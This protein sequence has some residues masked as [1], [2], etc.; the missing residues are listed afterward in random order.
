VLVVGGGLAGLG[1]AAVLG[2]AGVDTL[3]VDRAPRPTRTAASYDG[4]TTA[5]SYATRMV[6]EGGG[7]WSALADAAEPILDIR[8]A[9]DAHR[10]GALPLHLHFDHAEVAD[11]SGGA[12]FGHIV[13][14]RHM[15]LALFDR[16]DALDTVDHL[17]PAGV[18]DLAAD[19]AGI[20]ATL[21]DGR[22]IR[23]E[24]VVG[25]DGK[26]S[27]V[28]RHAG[29]GTTRWDYRQTA[30]VFQ[31]EHEE[32]HHGVALEHFMPAGPYA[33]LP[34]PDDADGRHRSSVV[35]TERPGR[36]KELMAMERAAFD[37]ALQAQNGE[38]LGQVALLGE[39]FAYPLGVIHAD[40]YVAE[41]IAL[42]G[43]AAH[44]IHPI[45]GQGLN[46]G[47]RDVAALAEAVVDAARLGL[48]V[49]TTDALAG[50]ER[51]RRIDNTAMIAVTDGLNRL[52]SNA[53]PPVR[54]ARQL[55]LAAVGRMPPVKRFFMEQA[56][57]LAAAGDLPR[58]LK[59]EPI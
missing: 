39:R 6:L 4:R 41:R 46:L 2:T 52:F 25:A 7:V 48:D 31:M 13:D 21:D 20:T 28:R 27:F 5:I 58:L 9:D 16:L 49:G 26:Q 14:N 55:G 42:I 11:R 35:W 22:T 8:I 30:I 51:R 43:E 59:G 45:A 44:G 37:R 17:A 24:L 12:P 19:A 57:G 54:L 15:R 18:T 50:Y 47:L 40:R 33:V 29:I 23:A 32:P 38:W 3:V 53:V 56:M 36:A 10:A 1:M 34:M